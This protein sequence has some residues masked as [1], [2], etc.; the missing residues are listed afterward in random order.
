MK[1]IHITAAAAS[2][3]GF[4][5]V[6]TPGEDGWITATCPLIPGCISQGKDR[7]E[8]LANIREA[9]ALCIE[10]REAEGATW[11]LPADVEMVDVD[12]SALT[13]KKI[14][15]LRGGHR[16]EVPPGPS[17]GSKGDVYAAAR[18]V[19]GAVPRTLCRWCRADYYDDGR[20]VRCGEVWRSELAEM[21]RI[22]RTLKP[23][24][25]ERRHAQA[26]SIMSTP[27]GL[28]RRYAEMQ[29]DYDRRAAGLA[30]L[31]EAT[32]A[33][34]EAM[35]AAGVDYD[36]ARRGEEEYRRARAMLASMRT[37]I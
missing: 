22:S 8:A 10:T 25:T 11:P 26:F 36:D 16:F 6:L 4:P 29:A 27:P 31:F 17:R 2:R 23:C 13:S 37:P 34:V 33:E 32:H 21:L 12:C 3:K 20:C 19:P 35:L 24:V 28:S 15:N 14:E 5:V 1:T 9:I 18:S 7:D 30:A